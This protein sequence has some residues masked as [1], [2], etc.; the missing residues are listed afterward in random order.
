MIAG[1]G[2]F[3]GLRMTRILVVVGVAIVALSLVSVAHATTRRAVVGTH[4]A[5][6]VADCA[7]PAPGHAACYALRRVPATASTPGAQPYVVHSSYAVGPAGGYTPA[8]LWSAYG[9]GTKDSLTAA[10]GPGSDQTVAIV[11]AYD[12]PNIEADLGIFDTQYDLPAC[13]TANGCFKVVGQDGSST[14]PTQKGQNWDAETSL[15]VEAVH[16]TCPDC[17]IVL[18]EANSSLSSNL[19]TAENTA[20]AQGATEITNSY[21]SGEF[22]D[23]TTQNSYDHHG[24]VITASG[25]DNGYYNWDKSTLP[26][27]AN[28]PAAYPQVVAV[29]GTQL[30]LNTNGTRSSE[31]V[32]NDDTGPNAADGLV[33]GSGG[34][35][36]KIFT[37]NL[38]QSSLSEWS[39]ASCA[40]DGRLVADVSAI[41]DPLT[42]FDTYDSYNGQGWATTGGTSLSSPV[43]AAIYALAGGSQDVNYPAA[44]LYSGHASAPSGLYD[45]STGGNGYCDGKPATDCGTVPATRDD[46]GGT[47][48]CDAAT[49][50]DGPSGLGSPSGLTDFA[51]VIGSFTLPASGAANTSIAADASASTSSVDSITSYHWDW[52]DGHSEA[53]SSPQ[54]SHSFDPGVYTVTL[55]ASTAAGHKSVPVTRTINID[56][57]PPSKDSSPSI[58]GTPTDLST[59]TEHHGTWSGSPTS[60]SY[61]WQRCDSAGATCTDIAGATSQ[62]YKLLDAD[63]GHTIVVLETATNAGGDST[64]AASDPTDVIGAAAAPTTAGFTQIT[65]SPFSTGGTPTEV[66]ISPLGGL[67]AVTNH[68]DD[69]VSMF[70]MNADGA[71]SEV[72]G[73]PFSTG[74]SPSAGMFSPD[75]KFF[76]VAD[77]NAI[78]MFSV[79]GD[80]T[81]TAVTGSPFVLKG[82]NAGSFPSPHAIAFSPDGKHIAVADPF[83]NDA[84]AVHMLSVASDGT[85]SESATV[86]ATPVTQPA[87]VAFSPSGGLLAVTLQNNNKVQMYT[88]GSDGSITA[89]GSPKTVGHMPTDAQ[90]SPGGGLLAVSNLNDATASVFSVGSS[91]ALT[92]VSGS[93]FTTP[94]AP[95]ELS[96]S[97]AGGLLAIAGPSGMADGVGVDSVSSNGTLT[98]VDDQPIDGFIT[99]SNFGMQSVAFTPGGGAMAVANQYTNKVYMFFQN[100]SASIDSPSGGT[101]DIGQSVP[102]TYSCHDSAEGPGI[103]SCADNNG[104]S[105]G[106]GTLDTSSSGTHYYA[107]TATSKDGA[108]KAVVMSYTV[109]SI[110]VPTNTALPTIT[111]TAQVGQTL[112]EH[113][114]VWTGSPSSWDYQWQRCNADGVTCS[115]ISG[116]S[117]QTYT[118]TP[119]DNGLR[120]AVK[121]WATNSGGKSAPAES[122]ATAAVTEPSS[123]GGGGGGGGGGTTPP[124]NPPP[125]SYP[126]TPP[127]A[128]PGSTPPAGDNRSRLD[129]MF[130]AVA[131]P[132]G[133]AASIGKLLKAGG[134]TLTVTSPEPGVLVTSWYV[135][136]RGAHLSK[137]KHKAKPVLIAKGRVTFSGAGSAKLKIKLTGTGKRMLKH[138]KRMKLTGKSAFTPNGGA[139]V[140]SMKKF[141]LKK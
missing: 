14:L 12:D 86:A 35:C 117:A 116:A 22:S 67:V 114:G 65:G 52:G 123:G 10:S 127:G 139:A 103:A 120:I 27:S 48:E 11:D 18:V 47:T 106:T 23:A 133:K 19:A 71:L 43:I 136:P 40:S 96:F 53:T 132:H 6:V 57:S 37:A 77:G 102:T 90:F 17:K 50:F 32:W 16:A 125:V 128:A 60:Y 79:A 3:A 94:A 1:Q 113:H 38:W 74:P 140:V 24:V 69:T 80:G 92:E 105:D 130:A 76:A 97:A 30:D 44:T 121:E 63:V 81:L 31:R 89:A 126:S 61:Q 85:L 84:G 93:P 28:T 141:T 13:T 21:G 73:S 91:G 104:S 112:T 54:V 59:L 124:Q 42:G 64:P 56:T 66:A 70:S 49:G 83:Y 58:T 46:C 7:D 107:V 110:P 122:A 45:V 131:S 138:A 118:L 20:V 72:S 62:T 88:V 115:D 8:D 41:G 15:D 95:G 111:G 4:Y 87:S 75:G 29:G 34:G 68:D 109:R 99:A 33:G 51:P 134:F 78:S 100:P 5:R 82:A 2:T 26:A 129:S 137:A 119:D 9:L 108:H 55:I 98:P 25:G 101:Y 36:S 39:S 135:V